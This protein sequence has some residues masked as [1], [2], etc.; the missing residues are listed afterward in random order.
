TWA[1]RWFGPGVG[2]TTHRVG[3]ATPSARVTV[4]PPST[5]PPPSRTV[6][7]TATFG[8]PEPSSRAARTA[9]AVATTVPALADCP[10]PAT[11]VT[12]AGIPLA[13]KTAAAPVAIL[14]RIS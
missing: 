13:S 7:V 9:G 14:P 12:E 10:V 1:D 4:V 5:R 11:A 6:K 8:I 3:R 2:P